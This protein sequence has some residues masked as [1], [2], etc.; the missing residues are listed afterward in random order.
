M[1]PI[2][3]ALSCLLLV[4]TACGAEATDNTASESL[5][6]FGVLG[7]IGFGAGPDIDATAADVPGDL[8]LSEDGGDVASDTAPGTSCPGQAG[9]DCQQPSDCDNTLC[10]DVVGGKQCAVPCVDKCEPGF[11]C[12]GVS[13]GGGDVVTICVPTGLHLCDPCDDSKACKSFG[14]DDAACIDHGSAGAAQALRPSSLQLRT[15]GH[16]PASLLSAV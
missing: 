9:C 3:P 10:I 14:V 16:L 15:P 11:A 5:D 2:R 7:D 12:A 8:G 6:S 1:A 4:V 13:A